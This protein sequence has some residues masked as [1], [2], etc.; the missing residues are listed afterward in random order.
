MP[1]LSMSSPS[2]FP[3]AVPQTS[4][5][6]PPQVALTSSPPPLPPSHLSQQAFSSLGMASTFTSSPSILHFPG[7]TP[8]RS[9]SSTLRL[10]NC[11]RVSKNVRQ[12]QLSDPPPTTPTAP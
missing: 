7:T 12:K 6:P 1:A 11:G 4:S 10:T 5:P 2:S 9:Y 3:P 8:N